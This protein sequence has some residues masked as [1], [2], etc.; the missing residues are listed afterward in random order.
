MKIQKIARLNSSNREKIYGKNVLA[1][2]SLSL[3][4]FFLVL[5]VE[6]SNV[7]SPALVS[8]CQWELHTVNMLN[9]I[10]SYEEI[11]ALKTARAP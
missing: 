5:H 2:F 9:F 11:S 10:D 1:Y 4:L 7:S 6:V 3:F 8:P